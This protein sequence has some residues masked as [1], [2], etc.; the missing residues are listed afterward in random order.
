MKHIFIYKAWEMN[1]LILTT[2]PCYYH[3]IINMEQGIGRLNLALFPPPPGS[4]STFELEWSRLGFWSFTFARHM[5]DAPSCGYFW[6][7]NSR[8]V[9]FE[10]K[11]QVRSASCPVL[12]TECYFIEGRGLGNWKLVLLPSVSRPSSLT[13]LHSPS[14]YRRELSFFFKVYF[15]VF[16]TL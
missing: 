7:C 10:I 3:H 1:L 9:H 6:I 11:V 16:R 8:R 14:C 2:L 13:P 5:P 12:L 4:S 15:E